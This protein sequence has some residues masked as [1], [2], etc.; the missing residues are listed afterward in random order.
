MYMWERLFHVLLWCFKALEQF[1]DGRDVILLGHMVGQTGRLYT[2]VNRQSGKENF[3]FSKCV[4]V[5]FLWSGNNVI[6]ISLLFKGRETV[7]KWI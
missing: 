1:T 2:A 3:A 6:V 7:Y 5:V 4:P